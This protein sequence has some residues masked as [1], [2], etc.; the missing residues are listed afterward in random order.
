MA[1]RWYTDSVGSIDIARLSSEEQL[2]L[3]DQI[4]GNLS[5]SP[6]AFSLTTPQREE[7]DQRLDDLDREGP[8]GIPWNAVIDRI[9]NRTL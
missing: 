4:W 5:K 6:D 3:L 2:S 8:S 9:R 7:L 1:L